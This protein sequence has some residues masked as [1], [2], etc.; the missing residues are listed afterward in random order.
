M[1]DVLDRLETALA[2][3]YAIDREIG[4]GGMATVFLAEDLAHDRKVALKVLHPQIAASLG[5]D[6]LQDRL[7][8]DG[9]I[10]VD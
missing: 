2:D 4:R 9:Q 8:R 5:P 10:P 7:T 3:T 6:R 1:S